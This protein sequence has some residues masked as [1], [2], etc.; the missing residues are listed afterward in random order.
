MGCGLQGIWLSAIVH[1]Q[2]ALLKKSIFLRLNGAETA[3]DSSMLGP[4]SGDCKAVAY[5]MSICVYRF[6]TG[7][8]CS[9]GLQ[10]L[11]WRRAQFS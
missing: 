9:P 8:R 1:H 6:S 3:R 7:P 11:G 4:G 10:T 5:E 2:S